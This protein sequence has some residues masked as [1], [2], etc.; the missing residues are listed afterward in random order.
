MRRILSVLGLVLLISG[1]VG[2]VISIGSRVQAPPPAPAPPPPPVVVTD[3]GQAATIAE[4]DAAAQLNMDTAKAQAL[5]QLAERPALGPPVLVHLVNVT[6]RTLSF[7]NSKVQMLSKVIARP[8]F[9]DPVRNAIV[10]Q[11]N[12]LSFDSNRQHLLNQIN[13]RLAAPKPQ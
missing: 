8:D 11:L 6:Y 2:C 5:G 13:T 9:C 1:L 3:P 4:I 10:S 7:E 12:L